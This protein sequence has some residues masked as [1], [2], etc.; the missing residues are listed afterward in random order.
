MGS[1]ATSSVKK[2]KYEGEK[3]YFKR[4][5]NSTSPIVFI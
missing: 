1:R 5:F 4:F 2:E 3:K